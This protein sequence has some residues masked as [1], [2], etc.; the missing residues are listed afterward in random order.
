MCTNCGVFGHRADQ[1]KSRERAEENRASVVAGQP[2]K[3]NGNLETECTIPCEQDTWKVVKKIHRKK[4]GVKENLNS[5]AHQSNSGSRFEILTKEGVGGP[6]ASVGGKLEVAVISEEVG[7]F[8]SSGGASL[9]EKP[10]GEQGAQIVREKKKG[11]NKK[12]G[13]GKKVERESDRL[14]ADLQGL[15]NDKRPRDLVEGKEI[16]RITCGNVIEEGNHAGGPAEQAVKLDGPDLVAQVNDEAL[17]ES[18]LDP[19]DTRLDMGLKGKFWASSSVLD[20]DY[21]MGTE[22]GPGSSNALGVDSEMTEQSGLVAQEEQ[23]GPQRNTV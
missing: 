6:D 9:V 3:A 10:R 18:Q 19:G 22:N 20:V 4:K 13:R 11:G 16:L 23:N 7:G 1:C 8:E 5:K 14:S 15:R 21:E 12:Q 17:F 2:E